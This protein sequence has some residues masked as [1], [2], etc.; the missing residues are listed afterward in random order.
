M[1]ILLDFSHSCPDPGLLLLNLE[2]GPWRN[3]GGF[4]SGNGPVTFRTVGARWLDQASGMCS[5][6]Y[7]FGLFERF[8]GIDPVV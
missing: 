7:V 4:L 8:G 5:P 6:I 1:R 2:V 3:G